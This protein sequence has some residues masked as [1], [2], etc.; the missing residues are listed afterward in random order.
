MK[1]TQQLIMASWCRCSLCRFYLNVSNEF[2]KI[3]LI[4]IHKHFKL[5][6]L[7]VN[8]DEIL[9]EIWKCSDF[10]SL[11]VDFTRN[12]ISKIL[13]KIEFKWNSHAFDIFVHSYYLLIWFWAKVVPLSFFYCGSPKKTFSTYYELR[14]VFRNTLFHTNYVIHRNLISLLFELAKNRRRNL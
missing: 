13:D 4:I 8:K 3:Y 5:K 7:F 9:L 12:E 10:Y 1:H 6:I 2:F 11:W 14:P